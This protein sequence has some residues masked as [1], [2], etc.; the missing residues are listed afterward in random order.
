ML[1]TTIVCTSSVQ[2]A[3]GHP[4]PTKSIWE[5]TTDVHRFFYK[6]PALAKKWV[7][8]RAMRLHGMWSYN[9]LIG[10]WGGV[11]NCEGAWN[12]PGAPYYGGLQM[13]MG[14][15]RSYG[16]EFMNWWG[17]ADHW[18]AW[19]Q[20]TAAERAYRT[21]GFSPWPVCGAYGG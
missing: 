13:D 8:R 7:A 15:Q 4:N 3:T 21:R 19:A 12:D 10:K 18:P 20:M 16:W 17:T 5:H 9:S 1:A 14:F 2:T 11:H 6:R